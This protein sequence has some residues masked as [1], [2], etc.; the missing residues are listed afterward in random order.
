MEQGKIACI[1]S[2]FFFPLQV[3][4]SSHW[5]HGSYV[6]QSFS[7]KRRPKCQLSLKDKNECDF[8]GCKACHSFGLSSVSSPVYPPVPFMWG[9]ASVCYYRADVLT[10]K[11]HGRKLLLFNRVLVCCISLPQFLLWLSLNKDENCRDKKHYFWNSVRGSWVWVL[12]QIIV[13]NCNSL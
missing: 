13:Q 11:R 9:Q 1:H 8:R 4:M 3:S 10:A 5:F 6:V 12:N 7:E 2:L